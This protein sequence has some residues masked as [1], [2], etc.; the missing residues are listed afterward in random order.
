L[1]SD[2]AEDGSQNQ[3]LIVANTFEKVE[4]QKKNI[5][6]LSKHFPTDEASS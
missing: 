3:E 1:A 5:K 4:F 6:S 2:G